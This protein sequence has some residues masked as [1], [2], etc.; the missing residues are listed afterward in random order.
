MSL[1]LYFSDLT[2]H[3]PPQLLVGLIGERCIWST[4]TQSCSVKFV[5]SCWDLSTCLP[6]H[7]LPSTE[8]RLHHSYRTIENGFHLF[9]HNP[10]YICCMVDLKSKKIRF[11]IWRSSKRIFWTKMLLISQNS[12]QSEIHKNYL[13][14]PLSSHLFPI[15]RHNGCE[16]FW[17]V[18][19]WTVSKNL[20][21]IVLQNQS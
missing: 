15:K 5:P 10:M 8:G 17:K 19:N 21:D 16:I 4:S 18:Y 13:L 20:W 2:S 1:R 9:Y 11:Y 3:D 14:L 12:L 7:K 6:N